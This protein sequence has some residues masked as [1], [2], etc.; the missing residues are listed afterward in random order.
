MSEN[1]EHF[2][3]IMLFYFR[4]GKNASESCKKICTVYGVNA[5]DDSTCRKRFRKFKEGY[6]DLKDAPRTRRSVTTD[7]DKNLIACIFNQSSSLTH[8]N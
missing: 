1:K 2:R 3:H 7:V 6:F 8:E 5:V 4:K